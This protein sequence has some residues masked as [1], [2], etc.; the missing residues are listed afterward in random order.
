[1]QL[2]YTVWWILLL[3]FVASR[4][5]FNDLKNFG[6][7]GMVVVIVEQ[8]FCIS[9]LFLFWTCSLIVESVA[10]AAQCTLPDKF[11]V[12]ETTVNQHTL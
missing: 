7:V 2:F 8:M 5:Y 6:D 11:S 1:M 9:G 10:N 12:F 3:E 4:Y